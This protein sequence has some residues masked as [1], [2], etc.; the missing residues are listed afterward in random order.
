M[1][2]NLTWD[3]SVATMS[4]STLAA[5]EAA[6]TYAANYL[7][8]LI[9][10]SGSVT[11]NVGWGEITQNGQSTLITQPGEGLGGPNVGY[12]Y[13]YAQV[14][15]ALKSHVD[16][17]ATAEAYA[18]LPATDP[19][20]GKSYYIPV[21]EA[22]ALGLPTYGSTASGAIGFGVSSNYNFSTTDPAVS[23]E[24][25]F[26]GIAMH[27]I[28]HALGRLSS[29]GDGGSGSIADLFRY[30]SDGALATGAAQTSY[31][32]IDGGATA[33][34]Y[35]D[36]TNSDPVDWASNGT[37]TDVPDAFNAYYTYGVAEPLSS[38][39]VTLMNVLGYAIAQPTHDNFS[40]GATSDVIWQYLPTGA[41]YEWTMA[42]GL[43]T[44][45]QS[46]GSLSGWNEVG[47]G[48]FTGLG[49]DDV[50]W[51]YAA[52]GAT[53]EWTMTNGLHTGDTFL[54]DLQG[55]QVLSTGDFNGN[56]EDGIIWQ[57]QASGA[58]YEWT[59]TDGAHTGDTWLGNLPGWSVVG[60]GDFYG[61]HTDDLIWQNQTTGETWEW[62]M[63]NGQHS[64]DVFLGDLQGW[65][66]IGTGY[67]TGNGVEDVLWQ[68]Q[69]SGAVYEWEMSN[70]QQASSVY[71]GALAGWQ[72]AGIGDYN[73]NG[74]DGIIWRNQTSGAL[75]EWT[76]SAGQHVAGSDV[77]LGAVPASTWK[78]S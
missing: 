23:G 68:N 25:D 20:G 33:L 58:T 73:G 4:P 52:T 66:A 26:V 54:G 60:T 43:H 19:T 61:N 59:M 18:N 9:A 49:A 63:A 6:V 11:I 38:A 28:A 17:A 78:A 44:G 55:W 13:T 74:T 42:G 2:I 48:N 50:L 75:Y 5:F 8:S 47:A 12:T 21:E 41:T 32:S 40:G 62:T 51:Q 15:S 70:G 31:F 57:N 10:T 29:I 24:G 27:E 67:F 46:L 35:F 77:Y 36:N 1:Q 22:A 64:G 71:L 30:V 34:K 56:G 3:S 16:S 45:N 14:V 53:Y 69:A 65:N 76:M 37:S 72:V 39:D 7:G